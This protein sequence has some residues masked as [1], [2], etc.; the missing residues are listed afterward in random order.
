VSNLSGRSLALHGKLR[1]CD[2]N[3]AVN[4]NRTQILGALILAAIALVALLFRW[5]LAH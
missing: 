3:L 5:K 4:V 2:S 1:L